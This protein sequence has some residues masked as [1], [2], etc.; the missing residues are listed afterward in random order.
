MSRG[1]GRVLRGERA[2]LEGEA[3][4]TAKE[5]KAGEALGEEKEGTHEGEG[6]KST[7]EERTPEERLGVA[8]AEGGTLIIGRGAEAVEGNG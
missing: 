1:G 6:A 7:A 2:G 4:I 5:V 8:P 3:A